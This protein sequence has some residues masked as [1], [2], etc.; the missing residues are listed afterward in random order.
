ME[1]TVPLIP[2]VFSGSD[3]ISTYVPSPPANQ[4]RSTLLVA[5]ALSNP[6]HLKF[7]LKGCIAASLCYIIYNSIDWPGISTA[8]TT[9]LL[10]ALSTVGSSRQKQALRFAGAIGGGVVPG[11]VHKCSLCL[12]SIQLPGS[13]SFSWWSPA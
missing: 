8:I 3:F 10:T 5:D 4:R 12:T 1:K 2:M 13:R 9:C 6:E 11:W 7:A